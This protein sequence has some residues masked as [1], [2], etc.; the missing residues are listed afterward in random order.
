MKLYKYEYLGISWGVV[1]AD[2]KK[3]AEEKVRNM[4]KQYHCDKY[5]EFYPI[6]ILTMELNENGNGF[7]FPDCPDVYEIYC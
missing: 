4:I 2:S 7:C 5:D 6:D 1:F 3:Q